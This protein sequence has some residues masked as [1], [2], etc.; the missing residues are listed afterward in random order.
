MTGGGH[1]GSPCSPR[2]AMCQGRSVCWMSERDEAARRPA[3]DGVIEVPVPERVRKPREGRFTTS[4]SAA[5]GWPFSPC[6]PYIAR[7]AVT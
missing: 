1:G 3:W 4:A 2:R 6:R 7:R 5:I